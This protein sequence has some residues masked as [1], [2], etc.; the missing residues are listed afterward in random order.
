M[1]VPFQYCLYRGLRLRELPVF[2]EWVKGKQEEGMNGY[3]SPYLV[4]SKGLPKILLRLFCQDLRTLLSPPQ[5]LKLSIVFPCS[6]QN[7]FKA[8]N[9]PNLFL[10]LLFFKHSSSY[11]NQFNLFSY[12][13]HC[14]F[15]GLPT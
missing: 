3:F 8:A 2:A 12:Y 11:N 10:A 15:L 5:E 4:K 7:A 14:L 6:L 13:V 1:P 9:S